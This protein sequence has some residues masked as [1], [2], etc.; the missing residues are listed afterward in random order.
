MPDDRD[1]QVAFALLVD[2]AKRAA[3]AL[4]KWSII[5]LR[6]DGPGTSIVAAVNGACATTDNPDTED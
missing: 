3:V 1:L 6:W 4:D 2:G 5:S